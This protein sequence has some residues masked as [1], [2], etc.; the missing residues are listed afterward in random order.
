MGSNEML[1]RFFINDTMEASQ[2]WRIKRTPSKPS[3]IGWRH[4]REWRKRL[5]I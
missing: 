2:S 1:S 5:R 3:G 4:G